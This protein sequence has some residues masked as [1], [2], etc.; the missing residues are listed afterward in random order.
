[1]L[2]IGILIAAGLWLER[3]V[4]VVPSLW[5]FESVPFG[6]LEIGVTGGFFGGA[7][8]SY[9]FFLQNFPVLPLIR[10]AQEHRDVVPHA[11]VLATTE[12]P[13]RQNPVMR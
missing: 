7:V 9:L 10:V 5:H 4:L 1:M 11:G 13:Q 12:M 3:Y 2:S 8:L 6:W